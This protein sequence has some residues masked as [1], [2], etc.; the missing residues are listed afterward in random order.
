MKFS[1]LSRG[2]LFIILFFLLLAWLWLR[3][4]LFLPLFIFS[5]LLLFFFRKADLKADHNNIVPNSFIVSPA[6]GK[7][8]SV[9][10]N[11]DHSIFGK[12]LNEIRISLMW[13]YEFGLGFPLEGEVRGLK[14]HEGRAF[15]RLFN[16]GL[17]GD[18]KLQIN[19]KLLEIK[20]I[21]GQEIGLEF[22][23]C[24]LGFDAD[25]WVKSGDKGKRAARMGY[26]PFGGTVLIYLPPHFDVLISQGDKCL[27]GLTPIAVQLG[28]DY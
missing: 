9:R 10:K 22:V 12:G 11:I 28:R 19:A 16:K 27:R 5:S 13:P 1:Y 20:G 24:E 17:E 6:N 2:I 25:V 21:C 18:E 7:V 8:H 14:S 4:T 26:F 3:E 15:F 23:K